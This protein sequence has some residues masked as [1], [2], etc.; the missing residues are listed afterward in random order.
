[1]IEAPDIVVP[2][3]RLPQ[4]WGH[5]WHPMCSYLGTFPA[6]LARALV[7]MLSDPGDVVLDPFSGRGTTLLECRQTGRIPLASDLNP[8]AVALT[9]AKNTSVVRDEVLAR[10]QEL[11]SRYDPRLYESEALVEDDNILLIYHP[12]TLA[13]LMYLRR[14]LLPS[15]R[16]VDAFLTGVVLGIMHGKENQDG[17]SSY[18]SISMPNT[19]SMPPHYVRRFV[20]TNQLQRVGRNVFD[21]LRKK[22]DRLFSEG[23][24]FESVGVVARADAKRLTSVEA[25]APYRGNVRLVLGSPPYLDVVNYARQNWIRSWFLDEHPEEIS[26]ELDDSLTLSEWLSFADAVVD[27]LY[28]MLA[29][30]GCVALVIGD[31]AKS[32]RSMI[33]LA[34]EFLR[35]VIHSEK[36]GYVGCL[37]DR[38]DTTVK[39]TRIWKDTKGQATAVDRLIFLARSAPE[40][41]VERIP[42][43]FATSD[44]DRLVPITAD[45]LRDYAARFAGT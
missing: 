12:R 38:L 31:V 22:I 32:G 29:P 35:R 13:Q 14:K 45:R 26:G 2:W 33:S 43:E 6:A 42:P 28:N 7:C 11:E 30:N 1:M 24:A 36:F 25:F 39:T 19:Y 10:V 40:F 21:L 17:G 23:T 5:P 9:R 20:Q 41:R 16:E 44:G 8:I 4:R 15:P 37:S 34:R 3:A 18:A 27:D